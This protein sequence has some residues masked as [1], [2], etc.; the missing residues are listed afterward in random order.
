[1]VTSKFSKLIVPIT[2]DVPFTAELK[3]FLSIL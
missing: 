2:F 3:A 1:M